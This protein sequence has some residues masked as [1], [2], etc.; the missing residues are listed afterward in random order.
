VYILAD[1]FSCTN[2]LKQGNAPSPQLTNNALRCIMKKV[3]GNL[4]RLE[5]RTLKEILAYSDDV[6]L[7]GGGGGRYKYRNE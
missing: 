4:E 3:L 7:L 5:L 6:N 1:A 2:G